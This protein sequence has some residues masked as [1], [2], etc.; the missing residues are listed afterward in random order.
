VAKPGTTTEY[1]LLTFSFSCSWMSN[2]T[3]RLSQVKRSTKFHFQITP[4]SPQDQFRQNIINLIRSSFMPT[5]DSSPIPGLKKIAPYWF[6]YTT[7]TKMRWIG[8]ELLEV[9]STEFRDRSMEYY[10]RFLP[11]Q[12]RFAQLTLFFYR[13]THSN[14]VSQPLTAKSR[15][16]IRNYGTEI[17]SSTSL[18]NSS[19]RKSQPLRNRNVVHRHEPPV[20]ST[21]VRVLYH[22]VEREFLVVDKP[23]SIVRSFR[24]HTPFSPFP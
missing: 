4:F 6:P 1:F 12:K 21:P 20:T 19:F 9:V 22:D 13:D 11:C 17:A 14:R 15:N 10:V 8:R 23:G 16:P 7:M 24:L 18:P 5:T 3:T 2:C